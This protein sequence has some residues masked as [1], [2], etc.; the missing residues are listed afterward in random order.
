MEKLPISLVSVVHNPGDRLE[1][2]VARHKDYVAEI[3][4]VDQGSIDGTYEKAKELGVDCVM[5]KRKKGF[6][7]PD[8]DYAVSLAKY[9]HVLFLDDDEYVEDWEKLKAV[10]AA[11]A[12][13]LWFKR[14]NLVDGVDTSEILGDDIQCRLWKRGA[15]RLSVHM[16]V[17]S[18]P[19]ANAKV[20]F[21]DCTIVHERTFEQLKA[22]NLARNKYADEATINMQNR[23]VSVVESLLKERANGTKR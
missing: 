9:P 1:K 20:L 15:L 19:A 17:H 6:S 13:I 3:V 5:R 21:T 16:H 18:N 14:K 23:Y 7:E 22:S 2:F 11:D 12:D 10:L 4:I 8:R